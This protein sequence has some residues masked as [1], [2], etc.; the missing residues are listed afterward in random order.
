MT[1]AEVENELE[2]LRAQLA[3]L[4]E[5]HAKTRF[6]W[7]YFLRNTGFLLLVY[8]IT[9][10]CGI[11]QSHAKI[12]SSPIAQTIVLMAIFMLI[13]G[14]W[15]AGWSLKPAAERMMKVALRW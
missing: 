14:A 11:L 13:F 1:E 3:A 6:G 5:E 10:F 2:Y 4:K 8:G 15:F 12:E 9:S 7:L